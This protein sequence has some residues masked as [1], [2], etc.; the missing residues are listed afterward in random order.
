MFRL[1]Q[2]WGLNELNLYFKTLK[3]F[4]LILHCI[5][6]PCKELVA[7]INNSETRECL[8]YFNK[9]Y[10]LRDC[11]LWKC[12]SM[13]IKNVLLGTKIIT[14]TYG[15]CISICDFYFKYFY[16]FFFWS[17]SPKIN[18]AVFFFFL[19]QQYYLKKG[20]KAISSC[21]YFESPVVKLGVL[22]I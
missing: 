19:I 11:K 3:L 8:P 12:K 20:K 7:L 5:C 15:T 14:S 10:W 16:R 2:H 4:P 1:T 18:S 17:V 13:V 21:L 9:E 22:I 6:K